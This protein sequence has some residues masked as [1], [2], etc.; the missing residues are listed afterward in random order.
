MMPTSRANHSDGASPRPGIVVGS[1]AAT[2][3]M[4]AL[5]SLVPHARDARLWGIN[6]LAYYPLPVRLAALALVAL[7]F[8]PVFARAAYAGLLRLTRALGDGGRRAPWVVATVSVA[9]IAVFFVFRSASYLLGDGQLI[10]QSFEASYLGN[11]SVIMSSVATI[12]GSDFISP[13][14]TLLYYWTVKLAVVV[15]GLTPTQ[16]LVVL[17]CL[18]GGVWVFLVLRL[19]G[20]SVL[21]PALR[22]WLLVLGLFTT[23]VVVFFGY[24]ENYSVLL[25]VVTLYAVA[26]FRVMHRAG[27]IWGPV[28]LFVI[29]VF[30][31]IQAVLLVPSLVF[32]VAWRA[33]R[34]RRR[35]VLRWSVPVLVSLLLVVTI[36]ARAYQFPGDLYLPLFANDASYGL[37]SPGHLLDV[38]N[39]LLMLL[40]ILPFVATVWFAGRRGLAHSKRKGSQGDLWFGE[41]VE[42]QFVALL[43]VPCLVYVVFFRSEIGMARDWDLFTMT[44]VGAAALVL[45]AVNRYAGAGGGDAAFVSV[46][47]MVM[48]AVMGVS[49]IGINASSERTPERFE[50]ILAYDQT[51]AGYAYENLA[52]YYHDKGRL[53][54]AIRAMENG[55][56]LSGNPRL[57][58]RLAFYYE[59]NGD[60]A[61]AIRL[62]YEMLESHPDYYKGR[63]K[64]LDLLEKAG[65]WDELV[66]V[67]RGG[68][69]HSDGAPLFYFA[70]GE[71]LIRTGEVDEGLDAFRKCLSLNP[72]QSAQDHIREVFEQ[73]GREP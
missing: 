15:F 71:G 18:L 40:P 59:D 1:L 17:P 52:A 60:I 38:A 31:H 55:A 54:R 2:L 28:A 62:L 24:I 46:P 72:P 27:R 11:D 10:V 13:G 22:A 36:V 20:A 53:G 67:A 69:E 25:V 23:S 42:W 30:V 51:H 39:E 58:A 47:A 7:A 34:E 5:A 43:I 41:P 29:A 19:S 61:G 8:V 4:I 3:A 70:L 48:V 66:R 26:S 68:V 14:T 33:A 64:L 16:G 21:T 65:R 9:S 49:W 37:L 45:L 6:H 56:R 12:F 44:S 50:S 73:L 63:A 57:Y 32:L 35:V